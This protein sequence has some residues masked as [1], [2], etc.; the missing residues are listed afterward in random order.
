M[1]AETHQTEVLPRSNSFRFNHKYNQKW[2]KIIHNFTH[3]ARQ[4]RILLKGIISNKCLNVYSVLLY[5]SGEH[6]LTVE[7]FRNCWPKGI[8][9]PSVGFTEW[10]KKEKIS[11][12]QYFCSCLGDCFA[13]QI[14]IIEVQPT[15]P[16]QLCDA[17]LSI[18]TKIFE[19]CFQHLPWIHYMKN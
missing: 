3:T 17:I 1:K 10:S 6:S 16:R 2:S 4:K 19:E 12:E 5:V 15:N 7:Y 18:S 9:P 13:F 8:F 11:C 14:D